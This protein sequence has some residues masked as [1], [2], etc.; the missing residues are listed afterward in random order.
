MD[1]ESKVAVCCAM[2]LFAA[3]AVAGDRPDACSLNGLKA[4][5]L[6]ETT[7]LSVDAVAEN[8]FILPGAS[9]VSPLP[10]FC[11]VRATVRPAVNFEVWL[12][13][14]GWN[15][16]FQGVGNGG[17]A[18]SISYSAMVAA[19]GAGYAVASTDTGHKAGE[20]PFDASWARGRPDLIEDFGHRALHVTTINGKSI[21]TAFYGR[22]PAYS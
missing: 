13:S 15:G 9:E 2:L 20:I 3:I 1:I 22:E 7:I 12:P 6:K 19:L 16:R 14:S 10:A 17:M 21:T 8:Q 18:G 4:L 11:R 5:D